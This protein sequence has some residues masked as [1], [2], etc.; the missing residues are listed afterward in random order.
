MIQ[1]YV[2]DAIKRI[3]FSFH[4]KGKHIMP[5]FLLSLFFTLIFTIE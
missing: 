3:V 4:A 1:A 5:Y 2:R